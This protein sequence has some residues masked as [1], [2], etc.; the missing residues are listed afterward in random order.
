[1]YYNGLDELQSFSTQ[2]CRVLIIASLSRVIKGFVLG[3]LL[4]VPAAAAGAELPPTVLKALRTAGIPES[5]VGA[6]VQEAGAARP[7]LAVNAGQPMNPASTMKLVTTYAALELLGPA[8]KWKTGVYLD[9]D[10]VVIRGSGDPKLN[11]ES[12][13]TLLRSLRSR[14]LATI[15]GDVVLDR[16]RFAP[17]S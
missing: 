4:I 16:S 5:S 7:A 10:N 12:F 9:G 15:R 3:V 11:Y 17:A 6:I 1:M 8:Y 13:W 14:G 2:A